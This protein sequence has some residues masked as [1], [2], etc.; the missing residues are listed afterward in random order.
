[1]HQPVKD[2]LEEYLRSK[3][4]QFAK[5]VP[6]AMASHLGSCDECARELSELEQ[7]SAALR[8]LRSRDALEPRAGFYARVMQRIE[9]VRAGNSVW[10]AFLDPVFARRLVFA[11]GTL[12]LLLGTYLIST[13]PG[14]QTV[15]HPQVSVAVSTHDDLDNGTT[16]QERDAVL[17][18]LA[19]YQE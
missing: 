19:N 6:P 11:S 8:A 17:V 1:M 3:G 13:E 5:P 12:V 2:N 18:S 14:D 10:S 9:D 4:G 7:H 16:P 15:N